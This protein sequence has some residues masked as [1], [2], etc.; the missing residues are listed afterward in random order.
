MADGIGHLL[1]RNCLL[2][3]VTEGKTEGMME[4]PGRQGR[5]H[6]QVLE[7]KRGST[8]SHSLEN[9]LWKRLW[10]C[11]TTDY[12]TMIK[13]AETDYITEKFCLFQQ[14]L[15]SVSPAL[16]LQYMETE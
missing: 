9:S 6:K 5:R 15:L 14:V 8:R 12:V 16:G 13:D 1:R 3:Q 2:K 7:I 4:G 10:T 11:H